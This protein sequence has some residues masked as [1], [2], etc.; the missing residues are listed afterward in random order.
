MAGTWVA[1]ALLQ[2]NAVTAGFRT[3]AALLCVGI[4]VLLAVMLAYQAILDARGRKTAS[5]RH[6]VREA[7]GRMVAGGGGSAIQEADRETLLT[8]RGLTELLRLMDEM[9]DEGLGAMRKIL[10]EMKYES[11]V[12][13]Q[14]DSTDTEYLCLVVRMV[15]ALDLTELDGR[16]SGVLYQYPEDIPLQ[17]EAFMA[18]SRL[19]SSEALVQACMDKE[20][21]QNLSFRSLQQILGAY[22]G[23]RAQLY[24]YLMHAPDHYVERT[25]L[26]MIGTL[27]LHELAHEVEDKLLNPRDDNL[28]MDSIRCLGLLH[29]APAQ[30][31]IAGFAG[32]ERWEV[33][34][35]VATALGQV[36]AA[37]STDVLAKLLCDPEW[38]VRYN[39]GLALQQAGLLQKVEPQVKA[40]G[41][42]FAMDMLRYMTQTGEIWRAAQ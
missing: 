1:A 2:S 3:L 15:A 14:L 35:L 11:F 33:R 7:V 13:R 19:G 20:F 23:D 21:P 38:Q 28:L 41:D 24:A 6:N 40:S 12:N 31:R 42:A 26:K 8:P 39:A 29:Y 10:H 36:D 9:S 22:T 17:Y 18:L 32:H 5:M 25:C 27:Q 34:A 37:A 16:V 30:R 4:A